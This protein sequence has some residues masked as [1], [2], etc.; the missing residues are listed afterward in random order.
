MSSVS[1]TVALYGFCFNCD[2]NSPVLHVEKMKYA[3]LCSVCAEIVAIL[4]EG[5]DDDCG[6]IQRGVAWKLMERRDQKFKMDCGA[7]AGLRNGYRRS[8]LTGLAYDHKK[9]CNKCGCEWSIMFSRGR[10]TER[11]YCEVCMKTV[12]IYT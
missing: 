4:K 10:S 5:M 9:W 1:S 12:A 3:P 11:K 8:K 6:D 2:V 7:N